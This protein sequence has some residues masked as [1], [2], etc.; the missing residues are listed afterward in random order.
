MLTCERH[1]QNA[2]DVAL[3]D[4][5]PLFGNLPQGLIATRRANGDH[6]LSAILELLHQGLGDMVGGG[7]DD[8]GIVGGCS[9]Q[10]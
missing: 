7:G 4:L 1:E 9:S 5:V 2:A 6:Q 10:P 3:F 8:D